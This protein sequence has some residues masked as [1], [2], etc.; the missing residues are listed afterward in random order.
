VR[1]AILTTLLL[2]LALTTRLPAGSFPAHQSTGAPA[3]APVL[4]PT[5]HP[6][7]PDTLAEYWLV[8]APAWRPGPATVQAAVSELGTAASLIADDKA[9]RALPLIR[10]AALANT[11]LAPYA[12]YLQGLAELKT[13]RVQAAR[14]TFARLRQS[15]PPGALAEKATLREAEAAEA[16][17]DAQAA[18]GLYES[19]SSPRLTTMDGVLLSLA[20]AATAAGDRP[21]ALAAWKRLYYEYPVTE[22][23]E[24]ADKSLSDADLGPLAPDSERVAAELARAERLFSAKR[25]AQARDG[26]GRVLPHVSQDAF[27]V[28]SLRIAECDFYQKRHRAAVDRVKPFLSQGSRRAEAYF[29]HLSGVREL[30]DAEAYVALVRQ[31]VAAFPDSTWAEE[32]LNNL[33]SHYIILNEDALADEVFR[34]L[35][36]RFPQGRQ[37]PRA[38]WK[39]GWWAYKHGRYAEAA[40][41]FDQGASVFP[42]SDYR[43]PWLYW[44]AKAYELD[45]NTDVAN[46][47]LRLVVSDYANSYYGR[48]AKNRLAARKA[49]LPEPAV[50]RAA[51]GGARIELPPPTTEVVVWLAYGGLFDE[52]LDEVTFAQR[53]WGRNPLLDATRAWLLNRR[54]D[55]R[56]GIAAMRQTYPQFLAL[57]GERLPLEIQRVIFPIDFWPL[58]RQ[59]AEAN[60]LDPFLVA[61]LMAQE[62]TF[63]AQIKSSAN[64]IGLMQVVPSTGR[65]WARK[66][67]IKRFSA[68]MLTTPAVNVR[69]GTAY[70]ADL[71]KRFGG[72][73][74]ALAGYNAG[75]HR[76][77]RWKSERPGVPLEEFIDDIPF[78][79]TQN[80][81]KRI[82]GTAEDY[83]RL[84]GGK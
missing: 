81:V 29:F 75:D 1:R 76:I 52:A 80:Y 8:P 58:I 24:A 50:V 46:E 38:A 16:S 61:A 54:G 26:F 63:D 68:R 21:R 13:E 27:E 20:R 66:L 53:S 19:L 67:G 45:G 78:P 49:A 83:R 40:A 65:R 23:G 30:G 28:S 18:A 56:P 14:R 51:P 48:L 42:R 35:L 64:A 3:G 79:E 7:V 47:R 32:A 9:A 31:L 70:F 37:A 17:G 2:A 41:V 73:P 71:V 43:P 69:I 22:G 77:A 34:E 11:P 74:Y 10:P 33:A 5:A 62:S 55:L 36:E 39:A 82:L 60:G 12:V 84:Y 57:G 25:Y 72:V 6:P 44:S 4:R 59:H 15:A